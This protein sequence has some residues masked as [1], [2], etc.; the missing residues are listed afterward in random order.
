MAADDFQP[1]TIVDYFACKRLPQAIARI[2][3]QPALTLDQQV[4]RVV[5]DAGLQNHDHHAYIAAA[6]AG[7]G[8]ELLVQPAI[9][10]TLDALADD[11]VEAV[12]LAAA[13][14]RDKGE[15]GFRASR[16]EGQR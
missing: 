8:R 14:W 15:G 9:V 4:A 10:A 16:D 11:P 7:A 3:V 6:L 1:Q 2:E 5:A 13:W 12:R